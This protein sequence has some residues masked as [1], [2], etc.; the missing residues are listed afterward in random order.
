LPSRSDWLVGALLYGSGL[1]VSECLDL[2]VKDIDFGARQV[3]VRG[4]KGRK[5]RVTP[6][7]GV[8]EEPLRRHLEDVRAQHARDLARGLGRVVLPDAIGAKYP[9][10]A[11][12]WSWQFVGFC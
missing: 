2:R 4:G 5:D 9:G 8:V 1:R 11:T 3:V 10:A 12:S 7:P 6:L